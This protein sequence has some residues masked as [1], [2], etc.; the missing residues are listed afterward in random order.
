MAWFN[1]EKQPLIL[2]VDDNIEIVEALAMMLE[3]ENFRVKKALGGR[4]ALIS[5]KQYYPDLVILDIMMPWMDGSEVLLKIKSQPETKDVPVLMCTAVNEIKLVEQCFKWGCCG[6][7]VKP[8]ERE[9]V[10]EKI[11][12]VFE[13]RAEGPENSGGEK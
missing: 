12:G 10:L 5:L 11:N 7:I 8:F 9:R 13:N 6:Y 3:H 2:V 4:E 1:K